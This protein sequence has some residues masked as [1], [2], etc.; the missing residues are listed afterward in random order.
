MALYAACDLH[1][2]NTVLAVV[3]DV[4]ALRYRQRLPNDL[5]LL[6][7][8]LT[9]FREELAGVAVESTYNAYWRSMVCRRRGIRCRWST[10]WRCRS[11]PGSSTA[12]TTA[13]P[14]IWPS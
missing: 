6:D 5:S 8:A 1:S 14:V 11:T 7:A 10:R 2:N 9:P 13:I 12:T 3:D 4:G